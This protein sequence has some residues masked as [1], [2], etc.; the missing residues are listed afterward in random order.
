MGSTLSVWVTHFGWIPV[1]KYAPLGKIK[2][3]V[4]IGAAKVRLGLGLELGL[5]TRFV[6]GLGLG[7]GRGRGPESELVLEL[8]LD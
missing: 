6:S 5:E 8:G 4:Y 7:L 2:Q 3:H 1:L